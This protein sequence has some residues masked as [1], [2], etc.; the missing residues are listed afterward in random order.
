MSTTTRVECPNCESV[1]TLILVNPDYDGPYAC[2]KCHN[3]YNIVIRA[4]QVTSA[5]PTTREEVDRKRTLDKP[6]ALSE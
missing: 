4:G 2:W 1:G 6:S 3:V 5:V